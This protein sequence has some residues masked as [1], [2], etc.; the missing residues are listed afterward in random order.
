METPTWIWWE[1]IPKKISDKMGN[2]V[3]RYVIYLLHMYVCMYVCM[4]IYIYTCK[5]T[6][7]MYIYIYLCRCIHIYIY[8][9]YTCNMRHA[10]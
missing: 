5:S 3:D 4:Y 6:W 2:E 10:L 8:T 7:D 1:Y 9:L